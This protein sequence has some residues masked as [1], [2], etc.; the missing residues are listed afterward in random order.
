MFNQ[1]TLQCCDKV[2]VYDNNTSTVWNYH[3]KLKL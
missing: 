3:S 2:I 1:N